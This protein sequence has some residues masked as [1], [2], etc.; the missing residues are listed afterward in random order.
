MKTLFCIGE[1]L[2]DW[3]STDIDSSLIEATHFIKK[4]GGAPANVTIAASRLGGRSAFAGKV[5]NDAFGLFLKKTLEQ[6]N[7]NTDN[8]ILSEIPT[9]FAFVS[10][11]KGGER[12]FIF[13]RGADELLQYDELFLPESNAVFHF[14]SATAFL[15]N[16]LLETYQKTLN[17]AVEKEFYI[18]FDPNYRDALW[19]NNQELFVEYAQEFIELA[20]FIKLS[21]EEAQLIS[22]KTELQE[23]IQSLP[24]KSNAIVCVTLGK[25][26]TLVYYNGDFEVVASITVQAIDTTGAGDAFVGAMLKQ[27]CDD[28]PS[29]FDTIKQY[30]AFANRVAAVSTTEFGAIEALPTMEKLEEVIN[31]KNL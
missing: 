14:G 30:V 27:I 16:P 12:D 21:D 24:L 18:S 17:Y 6:D 4:A 5:G 13:Q 28:V 3:I 29:D 22:G 8:L 19:K 9:T 20:D 15:S 10:I 1:L 26:G 23:A 11:Q 25:A 31:T 7:V 2:I